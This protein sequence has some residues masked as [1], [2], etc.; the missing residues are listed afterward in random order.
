[1]SWSFLPE[2]A[3]EYWAARSSDTAVSAPLNST[4]TVET[5]CNSDSATESSPHFPSGTTSRPSTAHGAVSCAPSAPDTKGKR[6]QEGDR[7]SD[8]FGSGHRYSHWWRT[9]PNLARVAHGMASQMD[10]GRTLGNGQLPGVHA[11]AFTLLHRRLMET[12]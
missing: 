6:Q 3:A 2:L 11:L 7:A 5:S 12:P 4:A 8:P 9:E 10:R 1:M